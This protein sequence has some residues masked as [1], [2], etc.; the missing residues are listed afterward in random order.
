MGEWTP[1]YI[2]LFILLIIG[3]IIPGIASS[4]LEEGQYNHDS[5][6]APL[7]D[8]VNYGFDVEL[9]WFYQTNINPFALFGTG[10]QQ[11]IVNQLSGFSYVPPYISFP[12]L[13]LV[14]V[15]IIYTIIKMLPTT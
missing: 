1:L 13:L 11:F 2:S 3:G 14:V 9:F 5:F 6:V 8:K 10:V 12:L 7:I 4:F 15:G